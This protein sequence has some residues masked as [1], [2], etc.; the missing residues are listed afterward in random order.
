MKSCAPAVVRHLAQAPLRADPE[1]VPN[2]QHPDHQLD[3][4]ITDSALDLPMAQQQL[5]GSQ[6]AGSGVE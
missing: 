3:S 6:V 4:E 2:D 1:A 5:G